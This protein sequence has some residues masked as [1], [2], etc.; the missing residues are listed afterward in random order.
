MNK[1]NLF[2]LSVLLL[3]AGSRL[4]AQNNVVDKIVAVIG[5]NIIKLSDIEREYLQYRMQG[6]IQGNGADVKCKM[7][8]TLLFQKLLLHQAELDSIEI[9][10]EQVD[11]RLMNVSV[12]IRR[13]LDQKIN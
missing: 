8:E 9:P 6:N 12:I 4:T 5:K 1:K 7:I 10:Q 13:S 3:L 2:F 11:A